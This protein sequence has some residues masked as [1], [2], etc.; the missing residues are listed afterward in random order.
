MSTHV[1]ASTKNAAKPPVEP[2]PTPRSNSTPM[3]CM[4]QSGGRR[5]HAGYATICGDMLFIG[6]EPSATGDLWILDGAMVSVNDAC[7]SVVT[8]SADPLVLRLAS[9]QHS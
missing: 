6:R 7:L 5:N 8:N 2:Q 3:W 9:S 4:V 1:H